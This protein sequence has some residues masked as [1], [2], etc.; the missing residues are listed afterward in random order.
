M[1]SAVRRMT[2]ASVSLAAFSA[3]AACGDSEGRQPDDP[4][5]P[6]HT[7]VSRPDLTPPLIDV[8]WTSAGQIQGGGPGEGADADPVLLAPHGDDAPLKGLLITNA[9]GDPI[10]MKPLPAPSYNLR[11]QTYHD[12]PVLTWWQGESQDG[13]SAKHGVGE[14]VIM[15]SAY[16]EIAS[17][18]TTGAGADYHDMT[19]T[20]D[21]TALLLSSPVVPADLTDVGGPAD[22]Y[23]FDGVIQ[24]VDVESGEV[25]F[26]WRAF[27]H[28]PIGATVAELDEGQGSKSQPFDYFHA[29]SVDVASQDAL[30]ISARNTSA[31][32][33][34]ARDSGEVSW[35]L[36]GSASDFEIAD[37][38]TFARQHDARF[39]GDG[40]LTVFD[41]RGAARESSRGLRLSIDYDQRTVALVSEFGPPDDRE[42]I[43]GGSVQSRE[44]GNVV[45]GWGSEPYFSE[46]TQS[47]DLLFDAEFVTND[48]TNQS[49]R[50]YRLPW[51]GQPTTSPDLVVRQ[52]PV[53]ATAYVSWN[54][55]TE[56]AAWR[57]LAG[58]D[59]SSAA[60]V[61]TVEP[62]G[63]ETA[64]DVPDEAYVAVEA[65]DSEG[66]VIGIGVASAR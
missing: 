38:A 65:L 13:H 24:E 7:F 39:L 62:M 29:N 56:V 2:M 55:A 36:G 46:F 63:F 51:K 58:S 12:Q 30:I 16:E 15:N 14:F 27:E 45:V 43:V 26:E 35:T 61:A 1:K 32:Y 31:V 66:N 37:E 28:V 19:L 48:G 17:V 42:S 57:F 49:Y 20:A 3:M 10:W 5:V 41:N 8:T 53:G 25:L 6:R 59:R 34:I 18:T 33:R 40:I 9:D 60:T 54:G 47:G 23:V 4:V 50:A 11:V 44:N 22:G 21:G 64:V 52:E